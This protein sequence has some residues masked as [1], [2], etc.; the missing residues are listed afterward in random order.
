MLHEILGTTG[1]TRRHVPNATEIA[2]E[3]VFATYAHACST[4]NHKANDIELRIVT[5]RRTKYF[6]ILIDS[7]QIW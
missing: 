7:D 6:E 1:K 5:S 3:N 2:K 4:E